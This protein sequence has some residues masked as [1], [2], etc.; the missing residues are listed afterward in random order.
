[1]KIIETDSPRE[2]THGCWRDG[3]EEEE[4]NRLRGLRGV[5]H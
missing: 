2:H 1:M 5:N 4:Q 3:G